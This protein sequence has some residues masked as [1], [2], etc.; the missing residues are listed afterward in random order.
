[1]TQSD[2]TMSVSELLQTAVSHQQA[3]RLQEA[4]KFCLKVCAAF[5]KQPDALH[6]LAIINAQAGRYQAAND[7]FVKAIT[8]APSRA[9]FCSNYGNALWEQGDIEDAIIWCQRSLVLDTTRAEAHNILGNALLSQ[10]RLSEAV[11]SFRR[12]LAIKPDYPHALNNLAN[13]LQRMNKNEEAISYYRQ[14]IRLHE[15]YPE[16]HNNLG[17]ALKSL[18]DIESARKHFHRAITLQPGFKK[19]IENSAEVDPIWLQ[20]LEGKKLYL[21]RYCK[22]DAAYLQRCYQDIDFMELYNHYIPRHQHLEDLAEKLHHGHQSHPCQSRTVD[23]IILKK[24]EA[25][26]VGIA[27]LV[28][29]QFN[30]RRAEYLIGLPDSEHRASGIGLEA[31]LLVMDYVFNRVGL[32][33][34]TTFVYRDNVISQKNTLALGF[35]QESYLRDQIRDSKSGEFLDLF[36]NGMTAKDFRANARLSK[37]SQRVLGRD[38]TNIEVLT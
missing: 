30:H 26:P 20:P 22:E 23:W 25:Q 24:N 10:N 28:E 2:K 16:A 38:I 13:V 35:V 36:G 7:Y 5:P 8:N 3:G 11:D 27:N 1:M 15:N 19:A 4:E 12:A 34:L 6:L 31:T 17:Q 18:G 37:L 9:D 21:R 29:I 32:N 33:K 14:A